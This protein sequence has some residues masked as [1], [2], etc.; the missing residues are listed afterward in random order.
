MNNSAHHLRRAVAAAFLVILVGSAWYWAVERF[1]PL[2]AVYMAVTTITTVGFGEV[3]SLGARGQVFTMVYLLTGVGVLGY[4]VSALAGAVVVAEV[5]DALGRRRSNRRV[6]KMEDH[7]VLCGF[8]RV[9]Q[10][11]ASELQERKIA[12]VVVDRDPEQQ[13]LARGHGYLV[14]GGD[15]TEEAVL[16]E[17]G[18]ARARVLIT[19]ADSDVGNAFVTLMARAL[20]AR[21]F[22]IARAGSDSGEQRM[23]AAGANR[24]ISPY[25]IAGRRMA[26]AAVQPLLLDFVETAHSEEQAEN[27]NLLAEI[28]VGSEARGLAGKTIAQAF[29]GLP[30]TRVLGVARPDGE[31]IVGPGADRVLRPD[32]RLMLYGDQQEIEELSGGRDGRATG[33]TPAGAAT[34]G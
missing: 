28:V 27:V 8:G 7:F 23:R 6:R 12:F 9:G 10:E 17:A 30:H 25:Q 11:I 5:V 21:L 31:V 3:H 26:L 18:V 20:N 22:I 13:A 33:S 14:V 16:R 4:T 32:D 15:A 29:A 34:A 24:V 2:E 19:A 1:A